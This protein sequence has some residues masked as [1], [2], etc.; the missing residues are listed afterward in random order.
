MAVSKDNRV[1]SVRPPLVDPSEKSLPRETRTTLAQLRSGFSNI[2]QN[3][4]ARIIPSEVDACPDCH[5]APHDTA[6]LFNCASRPTNLTASDL[7]TKLL[8]VDRFLGLGINL[9]DDD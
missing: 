2:I 7:W 9:N 6:Q 3:Y 8:D 4:R 1:L 5:L